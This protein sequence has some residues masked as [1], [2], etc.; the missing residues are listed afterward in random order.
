MSTSL[1]L[2]GTLLSVLLQ[3]PSASMQ[4]SD[5]QLVGPVQPVITVDYAV[6][7]LEIPNVGLTPSAVLIQVRPDSFRF[8]EVTSREVEGNVQDGFALVP[9][10]PPKWYSR[11]RWL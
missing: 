10:P 4:Q 1:L 8:L 6:G 7:S 11:D 5:E 3:F 9:S 2:T